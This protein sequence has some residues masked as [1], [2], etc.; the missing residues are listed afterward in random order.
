MSSIIW[1]LIVS[2]WAMIIQ[3]SCSEVRL[4]NFNLVSRTYPMAFKFVEFKLGNFNQ[5]ISKQYA[6][7]LVRTILNSQFAILNVKISEIARN[8]KVYDCCKPSTIMWVLNCKVQRYLRPLTLSKQAGKMH[9]QYQYRNKRSLIIEFK[10]V[11]ICIS[12]VFTIAR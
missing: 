12:N 1:L 9:S 5:G 4:V 11:F 7:L 3:F 8:Y 10:T 6:L 2:L